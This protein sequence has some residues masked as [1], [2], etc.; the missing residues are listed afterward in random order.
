MLENVEY[1]Q[2]K[3]VVFGERGERHTQ[4]ALAPQAIQA[5]DGRANR[6][7]VC[8]VPE[9]GVEVNLSMPRHVV[10][11]VVTRR[12][13]KKGCTESHFPAVT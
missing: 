2:Q 5:I 12:D 7:A 3:H 4:Q 1:V 9:R 10:D 11:V 8:F 13:I 6:Y